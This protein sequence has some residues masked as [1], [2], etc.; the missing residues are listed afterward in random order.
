MSKSAD[1]RRA[2]E[3]IWFFERAGKRILLVDLSKCSAR[4]VEETTRKVPDIVTAEPRGSALIVTDFDGSSFDAAA[5]RAI[6]ETAVF[7]KPFVKKSALVGTVSLPREF[8]DEMEKF[9][10][11]DFAIFGSREEALRWLVRD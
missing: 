10:R 7:D 11:R 2:G 3:R 5:L 1:Q 6:K 8:H 4:E 9:S